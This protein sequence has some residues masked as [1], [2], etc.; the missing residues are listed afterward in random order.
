MSPNGRM[1]CNPEACLSWGERAKCWWLAAHLLT[2]M[3]R[4]DRAV[5]RREREALWVA[6]QG[7]ATGSC[8]RSAVN[9]TAD[10]GFAL[11]ARPESEMLSKGQRTKSLL[12]YRTDVIRP[13]REALWSVAVTEKP[14]KVW[15]VCRDWCSLL[16]P[17]FILFLWLQCGHEL[18]TFPPNNNVCVHPFWANMKKPNKKH[19][20]RICAGWSLKDRRVHTSSS[21][22]AWPFHKCRNLCRE[23]HSHKHTDKL[24]Y[25]SLGSG[26]KKKK[27]EEVKAFKDRF[28]NS[29]WRKREQK[30][31]SILFAAQYIPIYSW[32]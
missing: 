5:G 10:I 12:G 3:R 23:H 16:S 18:R 30:D 27:I 2:P 11:V 7:R 9:F 20:Q 24:L 21:A 32:E 22:D 28:I 1:E 14:L 29:R 15:S 6:V 26:K 17:P 25:S 13:K 31:K 19:T 4:S 8:T